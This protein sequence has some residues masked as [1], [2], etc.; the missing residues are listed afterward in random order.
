MEKLSFE[1]KDSAASAVQREELIRALKE[2]PAVRYLFARNGIP[3]NICR[4]HP[5][6]SKPG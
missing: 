3:E 5:G 2:N 4:L 1:E 6:Q